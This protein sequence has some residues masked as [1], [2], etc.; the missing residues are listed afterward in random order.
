MKTSQSIASA[1]CQRNSAH[2]TFNLQ[3][4]NIRMANE[5]RWNKTRPQSSLLQ[6]KG[7]TFCV[8]ILRLL[9]S[10]GQPILLCSN[11]FSRAGIFSSVCFHKAC[12]CMLWFVIYRMRM[13][14]KQSISSGSIHM[15]DDFISILN[16]SNLLTRFEIKI[17]CPR[18]IRSALNGRQRKNRAL[19]SFFAV[20][21]LAQRIE[22]PHGVEL[23]R[24]R[25]LHHLL[26]NF[27][28]RKCQ[29]NS[30]FIWC[31]MQQSRERKK[32]KEKM[33]TNDSVSRR[34][35]KRR[36]ARWKWFNFRKQRGPIHSLLSLQISR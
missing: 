4:W 2:C 10:F 29:G 6:W 20:W 12:V 33:G 23:A 21:C 8:S 26:M 5:K 7:T 17:P 15:R 13:T 30:P 9:L 35:C 25:N 19:N 36:R 14:H 16:A 18:Q 31:H 1:R 22:L 3:N 27:F 34:V 28:F 32:C 24:W 11:C